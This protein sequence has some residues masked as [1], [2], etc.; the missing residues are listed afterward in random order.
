MRQHE[1]WDK[2]RLQ[3]EQSGLLQPVS[4]SQATTAS[5]SP[6]CASTTHSV[7]RAINDMGVDGAQPRPKK[8]RAVRHG[9]L[10]DTAKL[11]AA[12]MRKLHA[13][14]NCRSRKVK[15]RR[16]GPLAQVLRRPLSNY[17]L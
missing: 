17:H 1:E 9:P 10:R 7:T 11:R 4:P 3:N 2:L 5:R 15:V 13:C 16:F 8:S 6:S 14:D 12:L